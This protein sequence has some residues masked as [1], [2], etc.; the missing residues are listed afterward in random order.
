MIFGHILTILI[1]SKFV[2]RILIKSKIICTI[3][4]VRRFRRSL[5]PSQ[6][7]GYPPSSKIRHSWMWEG[8]TGWVLYLAL[9]AWL[10][11]ILAAAPLRARVKEATPQMDA[12]QGWRSR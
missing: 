11:C 8:G 1:K 3:H 2:C 6:R 4:I 7:V 5:R 12:L 9:A 10:G